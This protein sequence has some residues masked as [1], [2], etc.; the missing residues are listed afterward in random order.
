MK[1]HEASRVSIRF[2]R[3]YHEVK[4]ILGA[5]GI[6]EMG[7]NHWTRDCIMTH[8]VMLPCTLFCNLEV[9]TYTGA[10]EIFEMVKNSLP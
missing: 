9:K 7:K 6:F 8:P 2:K 3:I 4:T 10:L 1:R 5:L